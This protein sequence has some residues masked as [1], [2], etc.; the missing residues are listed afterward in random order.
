MEEI[1]KKY[2]DNQC[3]PDEVR[4][5]FTYFNNPE[6]EEQLRGLI[7]DSLESIET[8]TEESL[9]QP[10]TDNIFARIQPQLQSGKGKI[11]PLF[12]RPWIR[13]AAAVIFAIGVFSIYYSL[14]RPGTDKQEI[15]ET[16]K[17]S[18]DDIG[19]GGNK[20]ILTLAD[21]STVD[22]TTAVND[23]IAKQGNTSIVRVTDGQLTYKSFNE[24][25][26]NAL[27][28]SIA[29]PRGGQYQLTLSDGSRVWL[30][31]AS[32]LHFPVVFTGTERLVEVTGEAYFEVA[33]N[34]SM[35]FKVKIADKAEVEVLGTHFNINAYSDEPTINTT[36]LEGKVKVTGLIRRDSRIISPGEQ[37]QLKS[38]GE[39]I[40]DKLA[41][42]EQFI[43]WKNGTFNFDS[44]DLEMVLRQL[45]R[46]YDVDI[47]FEGPIPGKKFS[48]EMQRNL[49]ISQVFKLLEKNGVYC[50]MEG[51][52][53]IVAK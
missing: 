44:A 8:D 14:S 32:S 20:A 42:A 40:T 12:R 7:Y 27:Y 19:P 10:A 29:T 21:G 16:E 26:T 51:K 35:P 15:A 49:S 18:T 39:I 17:I 22:L 33:K 43:A 45:A 4:T 37:A 13:I 2:L 3:S 9:W 47:V 53:L 23:T 11:V 41:N 6:N 24:K 28:N 48:G 1:F 36:L 5:L 30:N 31:A 25:P 50:R 34:A 52:K 38:D 46:W